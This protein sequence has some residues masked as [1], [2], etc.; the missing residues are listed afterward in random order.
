LVVVN[1]DDAGDVIQ[2]GASPGPWLCKRYPL[3]P[4]PL[5]PTKAPDTTKFE[6]MV[7]P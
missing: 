6:E 2:V 5:L 4:A 3:V 7:T 1:K